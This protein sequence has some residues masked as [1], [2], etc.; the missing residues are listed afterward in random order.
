MIVTRKD[1]LWKC[2]VLLNEL[3]FNVKNT[4]MKNTNKTLMLQNW[5]VLFHKK[6]F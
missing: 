3:D 1:S 4:V 6:V 5:N 2:L